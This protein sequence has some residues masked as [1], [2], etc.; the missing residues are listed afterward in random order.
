MMH[1]PEGTIAS[2]VFY[3]RQALRQLLPEF[4]IRAMPARNRE[5]PRH[6]VAI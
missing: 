5:R 2:R 4:G 1:V 6:P 3:A